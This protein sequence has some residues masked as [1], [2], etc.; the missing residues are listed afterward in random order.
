MARLNYHHLHYFHAVA[1]EGHLTRAAARLHVSQSALSAQVRA[2]ES[3]LG[4]PLFHREG[5]ALR[6]T[7]VGRVVLGYAERIFAL[8]SELEAAVRAGE[9]QKVQRLRVG[10][11]A[12]LSR[13]FQENFLRPLLGLDDV[14]LVLESGPLEGLLERLAVHKLDLVL[15]N[16]PV[17]ADAGQA[18]RCRRI[19]RQ[20][21]CLV[22]PPRRRRGPFRFPRDLAGAALV[23]PGRS[24]DIR[25]QFDVLCED[26]GVEPRIVAEADDMAMLRLLARDSGALALLPAVVVQD[27]LRAGTLQ[28]YATVP[29]VHEH[30]YAITTERRFQPALLQKLLRD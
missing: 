26:A 29:R 11:V 14:Q 8:G 23:V 27:E 10:G 12:T 15:S 5:R 24:S 17:A 7:E 3:Q 2:L 20:P 16:T 25:A 28:Q 9:G 6:L 22:G 30:F 4:H 1:S 18:W 21:V 19:A 13:N